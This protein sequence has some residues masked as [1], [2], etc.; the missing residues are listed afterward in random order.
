M[1]MKQLLSAAALAL[2]LGSPQRL[3]AAVAA[4]AEVTEIRIDPARSHLIAVS[5]KLDMFSIVSTGH[6][7]APSAWTATLC[8]DLRRPTAPGFKATIDFEAASLRVDAAEDRDAAGFAGPSDAAASAELQRRI[9]GPEGLDAARHPLVHWEAATVSQPAV[10]NPIAEGKL[11]L[12]AITR[13]LSAVVTEIKPA[14]DGH[15][16]F[17]GSF[18]L[19][20]SDF[21]L[22]P[23]TADGDD[24]IR[25][26]FD[27]W[28]TPTGKPC[29]KPASPSHP[30]HP[31]Q[32]R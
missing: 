22:P 20:Q 30:S 29:A 7:F 5:H 28:A 26:Q 1:A 19:Q 27:L 21:G 10:A 9:L 13:P 15:I 3:P 11:T 23:G 16:N 6:T 12:H 2:L 4:V 31:S 25:V 18:T 8:V 24:E 32:H 17:L 14:A